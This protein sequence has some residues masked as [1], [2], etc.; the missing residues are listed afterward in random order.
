MQAQHQQSV[1]LPHYRFR[2]EATQPLTADECFYSRFTVFNRRTGAVVQRA[3]FD[4]ENATSLTCR[5]PISMLLKATDPNN[6]GNQDAFVLSSSAATNQLYDL[7]L[8]QPGTGRFRRVL[9]DL[10][11][12]TVNRQ[13]R[14]IRT[15]HQ[16]GLGS[17][18]QNL[19]QYQNNSFFLY[20]ITT[21][22]HDDQAGNTRVVVKRLVNRQMRI[23]RQFVEPDQ[24]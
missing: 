4:R 22:N 11:N 7:W 9:T 10:F 21:R 12:P 23:V 1:S 8:F 24:P 13:R 14:E 6:D 15:T 3:T 20:E 19:Y 16:M 17:S 18:E 5:L 2:L